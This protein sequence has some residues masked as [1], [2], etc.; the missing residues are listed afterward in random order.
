M[1]LYQKVIVCCAAAPLVHIN[2]SNVFIY[3]IDLAMGF[4]PEK[5][6]YYGVLGCYTKPWMY[7]VMNL[8]SFIKSGLLLYFGY[9]L[10]CKPT[11]HAKLLGAL[12]LFFIPY[13]FAWDLVEWILTQHQPISFLQFNE[14]WKQLPGGIF[15]NYYNYRI[16]LAVISIL[17]HAIS[18]YYCYRIL[19]YYWPYKLRFYFLTWGTMASAFSVSV[20]YLALGKIIY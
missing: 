3:L 6:T 7:Q 8:A 19:K 4:K 1:K 11:E 18:I 12:L 20:W 5:V 14:Q 9:K 2:L 13:G 17:F 16:C 15:L 10:S